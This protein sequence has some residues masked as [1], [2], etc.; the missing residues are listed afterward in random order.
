MISGQGRICA[1]DFGREYEKFFAV[2]T[3]PRVT[4]FTQTLEIF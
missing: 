4:K 3:I 1:A 2:S